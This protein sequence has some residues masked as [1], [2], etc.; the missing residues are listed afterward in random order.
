MTPRPG[1]ISRD[2]VM[3]AKGTGKQEILLANLEADRYAAAHRARRLYKIYRLAILGH[4]RHIALSQQIAQI[5]Q[6]L[7]VP[8]KKPMVGMGCRINR[9]RNASLCPGEALN[10]STGVSAC[11]LI[12]PYDAIQRV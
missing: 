12:Q 6:R 8:R 1:N 4:Y 3:D 11:P 7:H 2:K 10:I 9:F 5:N